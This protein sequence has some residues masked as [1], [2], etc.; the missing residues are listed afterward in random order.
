MTGAE[1][2]PNAGGPPRWALL[3]AGLSHALL[4]G[5][6]F[7]PA[8]W[9]ALVLLAP[10]PLFWAVVRGGARPLR[11]AVWTGLGTVPLW[12]FLEQWIRSVSVA[13]YPALVLYLS[14]F[15]GAFVW[16]AARVRRD[17]PAVPVV[18]AFPLLWA[19]WEVFRGEVA[20]D[21][22]P[23]YL[24]AHPVIDAGPIARL[25]QWAS[26]WGVYPVSVLAAL[27]AAA[28]V[29]TMDRTRWWRMRGGAGLVVFAA[30]LLAAPYPIA[31]VSPEGPG[32]RI[33]VVQ[34]NVPMSNKITW[35]I[36][37]KLSD[38]S[39]FE[40]LTLEAARAEPRPDVIVWPETMFPGS[41]LDPESVPIERAEQ[42]AF[43]L[44]RD[45]EI[46]AIPTTWFHD[47]MLMLQRE[48]KIPMLVGAIDVEG[49]RFE[50][51]EAGRPRPEADARY[52]AA[53]VVS[54]G[55][56]APARYR[57]I[58]LTPFG[59][60]MPYISA[61][62]WLER[63]L[64]AIGASGMS[65]DLSAGEEAR[66]LAIPRAGGGSVRVGTPI[67]FEAT[68]TT[69]CRRLAFEGR[70]RRADALINLT[71]DGWFGT[72]DAGRRHHL[73][74]ARW[75]CI[76]LRTPMVRAANTGISAAIDASGRVIRTG[77]DGAGAN[78]ARVEGVMSIELPLGTATPAYA[79][80]G[81]W[82]AWGVLAAGAGLIGWTFLPR[83]EEGT[84]ERGGG[85]ERTGA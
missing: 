17:L 32:A 81:R 79:S 65:F 31:G 38:W 78:T 40:R 53:F 15:S 82:A 47:R 29:E 9:A 13:G 4:F 60:V 26:V 44:E 84:S 12:A 68:S 1:T 24:L 69:V 8:G 19:A 35:S 49:L 34:T 76:E 72:F 2:T 10:I 45:G 11:T 59:E 21:G 75:R 52:N 25:A 85:A 5:L 3:T 48:I 66:V 30:A 50:E 55:A 23:W 62:P 41:T 73:L 27:P 77:P 54:G 46:E 18:A 56:V 6:S 61:W 57:K 16:S 70:S 74:C 63:Q 71:N 43:R 51:D 67:C 28:A 83:R 7:A 36:E 20:F 64:L 42:L 39:A 14:A 80:V 22:Y 58:H 37:Q 33:A